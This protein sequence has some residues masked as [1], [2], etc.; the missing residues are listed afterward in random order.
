MRLGGGV[1][2]IFNIFVHLAKQYNV[3]MLYASLNRPLKTYNTKE[4]LKSNSW[5]YMSEWV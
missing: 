1:L 5:N 4:K 2:I 3:V